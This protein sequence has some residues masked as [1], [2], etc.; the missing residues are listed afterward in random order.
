MRYLRS[1]SRRLAIVLVAFAAAVAG[2]VIV[3]DLFAGPAKRPDL[4]GVPNIVVVQTDDQ[5]VDGLRALP[6]TERLLFGA[7]TSFA[8]QTV[9]WPSCGPS[10]ATFL[11]GR[12]AHNHGMRGNNP[13]RGGI[14]RFDESR[15]LATA[16]DERG[17]ATAHVGKY[18]NG[19]G[20][21]TPA[22]YVPP[23]W[24]EWFSAVGASVQSQYRYVMNDN[25]ETREFG[26]RRRDYKQDVLTG[27]AV[28]LVER[29]TNA[30]SKAPLYLQVDYT[31]PHT[32]GSK[33][34]PRPPHDCRRA[35]LPPE[36]YARSFD[37]ERPRDDESF[38]ERDVSDKPRGVRERPRLDRAARERIDRRYRCSLAMLKTVDDGVGR[39]VDALEREDALDDTYVIFTSDN[40][41]IYGEHRIET[42]KD[43]VYDSATNVP[44]AI[45]GPGVPAGEVRDTPTSN[46]DL[47][48][49][50]A[51]LAGARLTSSP[52][53]RSL[54]PL[55]EGRPDFDRG[56]L[57][58]RTDADAKD[59][60]HAIRERRY[61]YVEY[62]S[63]D[64]ELYDMLSDRRQP[65]SLHRDRDQ[66]D[67]IE[68]LA[69]RLAKLRDCGGGDCDVG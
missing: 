26:A 3:R 27:R 29:Y 14:E 18:L 28:E 25:G 47:A 1:T 34:S 57:V 54:V 44:F 24:D 16:L 23:G 20:E 55:I 6:R 19:Y 5:T 4:R 66:Q 42:G 60:Y 13:P 63:G 56:V 62:G 33:R 9:A 65:R 17:Y 43:V 40:G 12:Y 8:N 50:I 39:I 48:P 35:P 67:R 15:T 46:V 11:S 21:E 52:D 22:E 30:D 59:D 36:R 64:I 10:R 7:G 37:G 51:A 61:L 68:Q 2:S 32:S 53:G 31:A 38:D 49:T 41:F 69:G 45:R 58:E